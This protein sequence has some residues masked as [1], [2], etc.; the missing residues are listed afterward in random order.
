[1]FGVDDPDRLAR[2]RAYVKLMRAS[3]AVVARIEGPLARHGL[4]LTQLGVLEALLHKGPLG[5]RALGRLLLT[6]PGNMSDVLDKL[7]ARR[8]VR[9]EPHPND[10]RQVCLVL[11]PEGEALIRRV[12]P[13]HAA[14][15]A[16]AMSGLDAGQTRELDRLLRQLGLAAA[17]ASPADQPQ[18]T[19]Q[20]F[21]VERSD[22]KDTAP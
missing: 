7:A 9:R 13:S 21:D 16:A 3:R 18:V 11:T 2:V 5:Q 4:T 10:R 12:F 17:L 20:T 1:M 8:L 14:D 15:I 6:S 19:A 22:R